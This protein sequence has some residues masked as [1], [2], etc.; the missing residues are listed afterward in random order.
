MLTKTKT[1]D[2]CEI[3]ENGTVQVRSATRIMEDGKIIS[4]SF[5]RHCIVPGQNYSQ[6][7]P[8]VQ[9]LCAAIHTPECIAEYQSTQTL[10]NQQE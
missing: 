8:K 1:I 7:D 3:L 6:E 4:Q 10:Q 2:L 9:S 5:H